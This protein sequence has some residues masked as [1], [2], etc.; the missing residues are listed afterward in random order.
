VKVS[1]IIPALNEE[2]SLR[3]LLPQLRQTPGIGEFVVCDGGSSDQT[4]EVAREFG[5]KVVHARGGRGPQMNAGAQISG[6]DV[7]WFIHADALP[8]PHSVLHLRAALRD[9]RVLGGNFR[10]RFNSDL[11][12]ARSFEILARV[13]RRCG[14]YYGDS[15]IWLRRDVWNE[16]GEFAAWPLFE[17]YDLA[18]RLERFA[19]E[20]EAR[21]VCVELPLCV[22][23]RR[24]KR[25]A[26]KT[27]WTWAKLQT[28][29]W[30]GVSPHKLA[31]MYR[32]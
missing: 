15:G 30:L 3:V 23:A 18:R 20:N 11:K 16:I 6:G 21:T 13:Q 2:K 22:S 10:L 32:R 8:H 7:L 27:L 4:V 28:L 14:M 19:R 31:Q 9:N 24:F 1:V 17:D 12:I 25:H 26:F 29:F 5:A